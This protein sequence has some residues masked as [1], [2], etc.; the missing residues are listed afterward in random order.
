MKWTKNQIGSFKSWIV[1][2]RATPGR[3]ATP[4]IPCQAATAERSVRRC[5]R[6]ASCRCKSLTCICIAL[7]ISCRSVSVCYMYASCFCTSEIPHCRSLSIRCRS[8]SCCCQ[9]VSIRC[10][11]ESGCC[12]PVSHCYWCLGTCADNKFLGRPLKSSASRQLETA[13]GGCER[14]GEWGGWGKDDGN[15]SGTQWLQGVTDAVWSI[16]RGLLATKVIMRCNQAPD[17]GMWYVN[18]N[19]FDQVVSSRLNGC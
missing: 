7:R 11:S 4:P 9:S 17:I 8:I 2:Q 1:F 12:R 15:A 14:C 3:S 10:R 19:Q 16:R 18:R 5:C 6:C 13:W